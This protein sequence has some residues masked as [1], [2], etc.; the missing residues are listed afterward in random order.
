MNE[1]YETKISDKKWLAYDIPGNIGWIMYLAGVILCF[2]KSPELMENTGLFILLVLSVIPAFMMLFGVGELVSERIQKID[3][4][5]P[6]K[7]LLRGFGVL[8]YAGV[9]GAVISIVIL[10]FEYT[11]AYGSSVNSIKVSYFIVMI[12]GAVL[13]AVFAGLIYKSF[14]KKSE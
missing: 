8:T 10:K 7:R 5:L 12:I 9:F 2:A 3:R 1:I 4:L 14:H 11:L 13:C 6:R